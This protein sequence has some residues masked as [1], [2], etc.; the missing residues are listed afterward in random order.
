MNQIEQPRRKFLQT[1][2]VGFCIALFSG[3]P[4]ISFAKSTSN[5]DKGIVVHEN[6]GEHILT[7]R[8]KVPMTIK[9]SK[10]KHGVDNISFSVEDMIPGRKMRIHKHLNNDELIFI[11]KG[12]GTLTIDEQTLEVKTGDV[13]F[14]PRG[15]WHG[16][17]NTGKKNLLMV[18]QYS[19]AGFEEYFIENG[20]PLGIPAKERTEEEYAIAEKKYGMV[21][22]EPR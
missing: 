19:P 4:K 18:F 5:N 12:E 20:T 6:E 1:G 3:L 2:V 14:V 17:D 8:R 9:I 7:G 21:Y 16:L 13:V 22:K 11:H 15:V 10:T